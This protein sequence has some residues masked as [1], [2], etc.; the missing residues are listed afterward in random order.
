MADKKFMPGRGIKIARL[1]P[2]SIC[3]S[4]VI[5]LRLLAGEDEGDM[6]IGD[7]ISQ[8]TII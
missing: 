2:R 4:R 1:Y 8:G 6:Q 7:A 3:T 5:V